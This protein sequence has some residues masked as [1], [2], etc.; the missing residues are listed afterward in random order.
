MKPEPPKAARDTFLARIVGNSVPPR[1][2]FRKHYSQDSY[3]KQAHRNVSKGIRDLLQNLHTFFLLH[4]YLGTL[5]EDISVISKASIE[6]KMLAVR[7]AFLFV[8]K[9]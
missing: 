9:S 3:S 6:I 8:L 5:R 1:E 4:K 2:N 7:P